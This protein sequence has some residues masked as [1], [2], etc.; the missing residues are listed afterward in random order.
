MMREVEAYL[1]HNTGE[2]GGAHEVTDCEVQMELG[3]IRDL[4]THAGEVDVLVVRHQLELVASLHVQGSHL[5]ICS[6]CK[7]VRC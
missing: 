2:G 3:A 6:W 5:S 4:K 7:V 1:E